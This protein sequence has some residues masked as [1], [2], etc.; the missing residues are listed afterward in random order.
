MNDATQVLTNVDGFKAQLARLDELIKTD[1]VTPIDGILLAEARGCVASVMKDL[2]AHPELDSILIDNDIHNIISYVRKTAGIFSVQ[3]AEKAVKRETRDSKAAA[4][5]VGAAAVAN[6]FESLGINLFGKS[7]VPL[8]TGGKGK[9]KAAPSEADKSAFKELLGGF[10]LPNQTEPANAPSDAGSSDVGSQ[11][12]VAE[13]S[14]SAESDSPHQSPT[15]PVVTSLTPD[16][17]TPR[18]GPDS[19]SQTGPDPL[20]SF[21]NFIAKKGE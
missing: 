11:R 5:E 2:Q 13:L 9:A 8:A 7:T 12:T 15:A 4:K 19:M 10:K 6:A 3:R 1:A 16:T 17:T 18:A 20:A 21:R 14:S